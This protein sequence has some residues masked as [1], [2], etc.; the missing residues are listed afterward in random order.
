M[1]TV[2][3]STISGQ[4]G[5][6][7]ISLTSVGLGVTNS[8]IAGTGS[9]ALNMSYNGSSVAVTNSTIAGQLGEAASTMIPAA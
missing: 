4:L 9:A 6:D 8:T 5:T 3:Y 1:L 2:T 7:G